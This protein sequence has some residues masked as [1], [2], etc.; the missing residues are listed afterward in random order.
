VTAFDPTLGGRSN[1]KEMGSIDK[2]DFAPSFQVR[3]FF[4]NLR[5]MPFRLWMVWGAGFLKLYPMRTINLRMPL[6]V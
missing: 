2:V 5:S 3:L 4:R 1:V 6:S